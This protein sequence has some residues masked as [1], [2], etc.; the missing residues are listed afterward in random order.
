M[1]SSLCTLGQH[2]FMS[3]IPSQMPCN[4][5]IL[6][7]PI[8][9]TVHEIDET[10]SSHDNGVCVRIHRKGQCF[11]TAQVV[12][13]YRTTIVGVPLIYD[14]GLIWPSIA[15]RDKVASTLGEGQT[16][17]YTIE[18]PHFFIQGV[19]ASSDETAF[20]IYHS[21]NVYPGHFVNVTCARAEG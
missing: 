9:C 1:C 8:S 11:L 14:Q 20:P 17:N 10:V 12:L 15:Y 5:T 21:P 4:L 16:R 18:K 13:H 3:Q 7:F 2:V 19:V 6:F